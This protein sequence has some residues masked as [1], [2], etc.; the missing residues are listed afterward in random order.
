MLDPPSI[1]KFLKLRACFAKI[2]GLTPSNRACA[3]IATASHRKFKGW[4]QTRGGT[5]AGGFVARLPCTDY[6]ILR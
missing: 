3:A 4:F 2:K 1:T 5:V 6:N